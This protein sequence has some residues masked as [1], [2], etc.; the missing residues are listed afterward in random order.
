MNLTRGFA[1]LFFVPI[2]V[3]IINLFNEHRWYKRDKEFNDALTSILK[4]KEQE[5]EAKKFRDS[6]K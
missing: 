1:I 2:I 3:I 5:R 6:L 4:R